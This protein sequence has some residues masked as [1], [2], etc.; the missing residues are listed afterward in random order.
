MD[1]CYFPNFFGFNALDKKE[2]DNASPFNLHLPDGRIARAIITQDN[3]KSLQTNPQSF[4]G[5]WI[6]RDVLGLKARELLT[7]RH[8]YA[9]GVDSLK[10]TKMDENNFTIEL[11]ETYAYEKWKLEIMD[12]IEKHNIQ[13]PIFRPELFDEVEE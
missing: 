3:G 2:R 4:L 1:S 7:M 6:L 12:E 8:L 13:K 11:A 9:L 10:I 5:E